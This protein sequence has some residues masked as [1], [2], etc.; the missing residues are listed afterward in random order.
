MKKERRKPDILSKLQREN[1]QLREELAV[2]R[3]VEQ[4]K[5]NRDRL[6]M[7][8]LIFR[9]IPH[10]IMV[11]DEDGRFLFVNEALANFYGAASPADVLGKTDS[12]Y[13][14]NKDQL[15]RFREADLRVIKT[16]AP[17]YLDKE[18]NTDTN[19]KKHYL[20]TIKVPLLNPDGTVH[21]VVVSTVVDKV[22]ALEQR[23]HNQQLEAKRRRDMAIL[24][25]K[26]AHKLNTR[27]ATLETYVFGLPG[28]KSDMEDVLK[29]IDEI[30]GF[31]DDFLKLATSN[32]LRVSRTDLMTIFRRALIHNNTMSIYVNDVP[33][34]RHV[35]LDPRFALIADETKLAD[36]FSE[37]LSNS[38]KAASHQSLV[39]RIDAQELPKVQLGTFA[40]ATKIRI[41]FRDN[42][43]GVRRELKTKLF[44]AFESGSTEGTGLG[45]AMVKE[46][47]E[48]HGGSVAENGSPGM[49]A[50]FEIILP[51]K[52]TDNP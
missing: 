42:G 13:N 36:V 49:G 44:E 52:L 45:L 6:A 48:A 46:V 2:L 15:D 26:L 38:I 8:D 3:R 47:V 5:L 39:I 17:V 19:G 18:E 30:K 24:A 9:T 22:V 51:T 29:K 50:S 21:V 1:S 34:T 12:D 40:P 28:T 33:W 7:F 35:E 10:L 27:I 20:H 31:G 25:S 14:P 41:R 23:L 4:D 11:K 32:Q 16:K 43:P 37:L